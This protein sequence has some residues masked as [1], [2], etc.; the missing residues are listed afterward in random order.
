M[1]DARSNATSRD[2]ERGAVLVLTIVVMVVIGLIS[3][4]LLAI[5]T[6]GVQQRTT[7]DT[8][9]NREYAADAAI[10][11][12]IARVRGITTA[13]GVGL[14]PCAQNGPDYTTLNGVSIRV[15]CTNAPAVTTLGLLERDVVFT[16]CVDASPSVACTDATAVIRAQVSF[17]TVSSG[18]TTIARTYVQSWSVNK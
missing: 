18:S 1:T 6:S 5:I 12:A 4:G 13:P 9:R 8:A 16:A 11:T 7:L 10:E 17:Q 15:D 2:S 3:A 14:T